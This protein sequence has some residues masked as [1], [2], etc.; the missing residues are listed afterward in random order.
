MGEKQLN[1]VLDAKTG[2]KDTLPTVLGYVGIGTA[3]GIIG[4]FLMV[5]I[6]EEAFDVELN[7]PLHTCPVP[8]NLCQGGMAAPSRAESVRIFRE[9]WLVDLL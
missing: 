2:V 6:V 7:N 1:N 4:N 9:N 8:L 5:D 3:F